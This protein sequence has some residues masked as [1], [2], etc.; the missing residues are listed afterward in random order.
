MRDENVP[1]WVVVAVF[2]GLSVVVAV[3]GSEVLDARVAARQA[4]FEG[5]YQDIRSADQVLDRLAPAAAEDPDANA[6]FL[7]QAAACRRMVAAYNT[8]AREVLFSEFDNPRLPAQIS[9]FD[10]AT[11]CGG[12]R[13]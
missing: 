3:V 2:V 11:D 8:E 7:A 6:Y 12:T 4:R 13:R 10:P 1:G 9:L 5:A